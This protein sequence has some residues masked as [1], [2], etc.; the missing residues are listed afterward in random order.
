ML[1]QDDEEEGPEISETECDRELK[2]YSKAKGNA[3]TTTRKSVTQYSFFY[4]T[5]FVH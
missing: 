5:V 3:P 1:T 4:I 2:M